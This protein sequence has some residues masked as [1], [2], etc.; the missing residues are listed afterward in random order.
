[1]IERVKSGYPKQG[2]IWHF[3]GSGKSLLMVFAAQKLRMTPEL[4]NPT[5]VIVDDRIDLETQITGDF[6]AADIPNL[7]SLVS[8]VDLMDFFEQ[9][10]R[11]IAIT[12][13]YRFGDVERALNS[14]DNI[15]LLVDEAH[16]TQEGDL[17]E[18]CALHYRMRSFLD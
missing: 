10:M 2:L 8:K 6:N 7:Q 17:G 16:R 11:K 3:Q 13:I 18:K 4:Q 1:M 15:I 12:T 9:D 14:R 5:V